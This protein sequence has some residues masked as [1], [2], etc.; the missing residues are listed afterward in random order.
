MQSAL[1]AARAAS[2]TATELTHR[3]AHCGLAATERLLQDT[4]QLDTLSAAAGDVLKLLRAET[5][6]LPVSVV[7]TLRAVYAISCL[8][9]AHGPLH[10]PARAAWEGAD[11]QQRFAGG[12]SVLSPAESSQL[13]LCLAFSMAA[14]GGALAFL[15]GGAAR[16]V[17]SGMLDD[18]R[19]GLAERLGLPLCDVPLFEPS[20]TVFRPAHYVAVSR[21]HS[22]IVVSFR[23][24]LSILDSL[25]NLLARPCAAPGG[26]LAHEGMQC[27]ARDLAAGALGALIAELRAAHPGFALRFTGHSLGAGIAAL[28]TRHY[29]AAGAGDVHCYAFAPPCVLSLAEA[30]AAASCVTSCVL[31]D[32]I[33]PRLSLGHID[34]LRCAIRALDEPGACSRIAEELSRALEDAEPGTPGA[35]APVQND[36]VASVRS[37]LLAQ[38]QNERRLYPPGRIVWLPAEQPAA[39]RV[40]PTAA[41]CEMVIS[42]QMIASHMPQAYEKAVLLAFPAP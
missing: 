30:G 18:S 2:S 37:G 32:D 13:R 6:E 42:A 11:V 16:E 21:A 34:D 19:A 39:A 29:Q 40:V 31:G 22:A 41:F 25:T 28:L 7:G 5:S 15:R 12:P 36:H 4:A 33:V 26:G 23:G 24:S 27:A 1:A 17:L 38:M 20:S 14:Y 9:A 35:E 10:P 8:Q 3:V